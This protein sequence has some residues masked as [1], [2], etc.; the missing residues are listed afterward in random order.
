MGRKKSILLIAAGVAVAVALGSTLALTLGSAGGSQASPSRTPRAHDTP[1][2]QATGGPETTLCMEDNAPVSNGAYIVQNNEFATSVPE[3][4]ST[5]GDPGFRVT[6][7]VIDIPSDEGPG[8]YP[9][10]YRGCHWGKCSPV[11]LR[12]VKVSDLTTGK[13]TTSWSTSQP[14][15]SN[16][17][18]V[19][20]DIWF[21]RT[22][23]TVTQ[24]DCTEM[25]VWLNHSGH[26]IP[27]GTLMARGVRVGNHRYNIWEGPQPW[28]DTVTYDMAT[29]TTSVSG[30]DIGTLAQNAVSRGYLP[31]SC[32][33]MDIEA[34][35]EIWHGGAGLATN[36]F[37]VHEAAKL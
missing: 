11:P 33:L 13:V 31:R 32:Y 28:G 12:P 22:P 5:D 3:C 30:L 1:S 18:D 35:F 25:M 20:Y 14:G 29:A 8:A 17:Y 19:A 34:G 16:I 6:H 26:V 27:H 9:S 15:G 24:P 23:T 37:A 7:S 21:N 2:S 4:V 36:S 10:I